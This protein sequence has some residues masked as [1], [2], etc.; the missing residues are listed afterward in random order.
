M[1]EWAG[2]QGRQES[3]PFLKGVDEQVIPLGDWNL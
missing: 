1:R 2:R 3:H